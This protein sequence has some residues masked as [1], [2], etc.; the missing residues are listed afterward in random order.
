MTKIKVRIIGL[1][2][3]SNPLIARFIFRCY[4]TLLC[5]ATTRYCYILLAQV[6][7]FQVWG[8]HGFSGP[9]ASTVL[10]K[11]SIY[12]ITISHYYNYIL[13]STTDLQSLTF[14]L[15]F[16]YTTIIDFRLFVMKRI[17]SYDSKTNCIA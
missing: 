17:C 13:S 2:F 6:G 14:P 9:S 12:S 8:C 7:T 3:L 16:H 15:Y 1:E 4:I 10:N 5:H 11:R